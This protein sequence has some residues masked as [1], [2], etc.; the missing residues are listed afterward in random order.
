MTDVA[1]DAHR[2]LCGAAQAQEIGLNGG[3]A[4]AGGEN[5]SGKLADSGIAFLLINDS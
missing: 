3:S 1:T 5:L 4:G 2:R